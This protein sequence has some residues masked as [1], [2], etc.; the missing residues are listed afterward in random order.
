MV[1]DILPFQAQCGYTEIDKID[2]Q[3]V[4]KIVYGVVQSGITALP[5]IGDI[6]DMVYAAYDPFSPIAN[7]HGLNNELTE[8][9]NKKF[10]EMEDCFQETI[11]TMMDEEHITELGNDING[12]TELSVKSI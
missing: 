4:D 12:V 10:N 8:K 3:I 11:Q 1:E 7:E 2:E 6:A 5:V 9:V